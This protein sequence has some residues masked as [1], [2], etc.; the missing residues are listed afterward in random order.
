MFSILELVNK[1]LFLDKYG[2]LS[3]SQMTVNIF[4]NINM[5]TN[6]RRTDDTISVSGVGGTLKVNQCGDL[7]GFG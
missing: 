3:D 2:I 5:V 7:P 6:V 4:N 1:R